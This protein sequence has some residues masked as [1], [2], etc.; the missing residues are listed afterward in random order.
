MRRNEMRC[1]GVIIVGKIKRGNPVE[2]ADRRRE[3]E[4]EEHLKRVGSTN[5]WKEEDKGQSVK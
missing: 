1:G 3:R 5:I 4:R 2:R